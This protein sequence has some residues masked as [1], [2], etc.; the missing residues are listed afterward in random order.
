MYVCEHKQLGFPLKWYTQSMFTFGCDNERI[1]AKN[2]AKY[3]GMEKKNQLTLF[4]ASET[5][6][7]ICSKRAV[8]SA[9][10]WLCKAIFS[11]NFRGFAIMA[12]LVW[13]ETVQRLL[14]M[15]L[16]CNNHSQRIELETSKFRKRKNIK[17]ECFYPK[18][19]Y[20]TSFSL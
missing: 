1:T 19:N 8:S 18:L 13:L 16:R 11:L 7:I 10:F 6:F 3:I 17:S 14:G 5:S 9:C 20:F 15:L 2:H 4:V 12:A